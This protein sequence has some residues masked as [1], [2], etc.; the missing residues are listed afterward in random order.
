MHGKVVVNAE[1]SHPGEEGKPIREH[2]E[3]SPD[4]YYLYGVQPVF[5]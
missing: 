2:V 5:Y 4:E 3:D 1:N